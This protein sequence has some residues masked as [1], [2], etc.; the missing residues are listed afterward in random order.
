[1]R[2]GSASM[3]TC[4]TPPPMAITCDTPGT[5]S[6]RGRSVKSAKRRSSGGV[7][8]ESHSRPSSRIS[9]MIELTGPIAG[10]SPS[11]I[12]SRASASRSATVCR[13]RA[14]SAPQPNST[15]TTLNPIPLVAR[16]RCTPETPSS[17]CSSG[18]VTS[19]STSSGERPGASV[20]TVTVGRLRSGNTSIGMRGTTH[21]P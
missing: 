18:T 20:M 1:M 2:A 12:C 14:T 3:C 15:A 19:S 10:V 8:V 13:T 16:T 6:S 5:D 4:S 11:G 21:A 7:M 9:P 17:D